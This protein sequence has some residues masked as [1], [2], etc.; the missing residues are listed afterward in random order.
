MA[1]PRMPPPTRAAWGSKLSLMDMSL[2]WA[3][4][5]QLCGALLGQ[6]RVRKKNVF[7]RGKVPNPAK[8]HQKR[9]GSSHI[10]KPPS[11]CCHTR[12]GMTGTRRAVCHL[13]CHPSFLR[14]LAGIGANR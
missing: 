13:V 11:E 7:L 9:M 2:M 4:R 1:T 14:H 3:C 6:R 8:K 5:V 10:S 12:G